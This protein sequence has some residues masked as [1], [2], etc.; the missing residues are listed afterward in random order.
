MQVWEAMF[1]FFF[2]QYLS[3]I[4]AEASS[5]CKAVFE[6]FKGSILHSNDE[7]TENVILWTMQM[8]TVF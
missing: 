8:Q 1:G 6:V 7:C 3:S 2:S 4:G 5:D